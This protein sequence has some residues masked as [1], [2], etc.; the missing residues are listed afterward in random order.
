[1]R[2]TEI[3]LV[4][5]LDG[6]PAAET[7]T[8]GYRGAQYEIDLSAEHV[9]EFDKAMRRYVKEARERPANDPR[10]QDIRKWAR[11]HGLKVGERGRIPTNVMREYYR[12]IA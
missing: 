12:E 6:N 8:F 4:D 10:P 11:R 9:R 2:K 1:M 3:T 5:D 7:I